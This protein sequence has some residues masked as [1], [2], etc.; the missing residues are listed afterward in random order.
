MGLEFV[1]QMHGDIG[2]ASVCLSNGFLP[3]ALYDT[4]FAAVLASLQVQQLLN[5]NDVMTKLLRVP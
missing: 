4:L 1:F 3:W 5:D 2:R